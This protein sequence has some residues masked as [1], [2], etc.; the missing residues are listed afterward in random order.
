MCSGSNEEASVAGS[1]GTGGT[2]VKDW[3]RRWS[4]ARHEGLCVLLWP[5]SGDRRTK[6]CFKQ[7]VA[8]I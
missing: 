6:E 4:G 1:E 2:V 5:C 8:G 3:V 7:R